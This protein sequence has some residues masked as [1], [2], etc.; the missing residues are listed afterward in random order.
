LLGDDAADEVY[1][2]RDLRIT[3]AIAPTGSAT[4]VA[5]GYRVSGYWQWNSG[6]V[7]SN[8]PL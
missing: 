7:H 3:V 2:T 4:P 6:G 5:G 8:G 1:A